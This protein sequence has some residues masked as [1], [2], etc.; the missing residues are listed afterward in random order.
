MLGYQPQVV[1]LTIIAFLVSRCHAVHGNGV[2]YCLSLRETA[3]QNDEIA[4]V[5]LLT[6]GRI[7]KRCLL[8][9]QVDPMI[10]LQNTSGR[11]KETW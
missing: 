11:I 5:F 3:T 6:D 7:S 9:S 4:T 2:L 8:P 1:Q 10:Y